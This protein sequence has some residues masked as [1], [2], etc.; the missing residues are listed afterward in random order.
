MGKVQTNFNGWIPG[1][2]SR[3]VDEVKVA[4]ANVGATPIKFGDP[5]FYKAAAKGVVGYGDAAATAANFIG[6]CVRE[7]AKTPDEY[8]SSL[9]QINPQEI[10][11]VLTRGCVTVEIVSAATVGAPAYLDANGKWT[12]TSSSTMAAANTTFKSVAYPKAEVLIATR[13]F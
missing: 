11:D 10:C 3:S 2:V 8:D 9:A 13:K 5:V 4:F 7:G 1:T 12:G 6:I